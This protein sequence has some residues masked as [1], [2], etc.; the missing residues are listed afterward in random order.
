M[1]VFR[2]KLSQVPRPGLTLRRLH[3]PERR[4]RSVMSNTVSFCN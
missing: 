4:E 3:W 1:D 2:L